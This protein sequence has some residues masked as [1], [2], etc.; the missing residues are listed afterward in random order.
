MPIC[1]AI[2]LILAPHALVLPQVNQREADVES[3]LAK[4]EP[5]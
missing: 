2:R 1:A 4:I 3:T 5:L